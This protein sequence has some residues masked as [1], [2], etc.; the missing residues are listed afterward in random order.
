[1]TLRNF[2][3]LVFIHRLCT[4]IEENGMTYEYF[5]AILE[6]TTNLVFP[7]QVTEFSCHDNGSFSFKCTSGDVSYYITL[8]SDP[9]YPRNIVIS[10]KHWS[11]VILI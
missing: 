11:N 10:K 1:M 6:E 7:L 9:L 5:F 4:W 2:D 3:E 8:D